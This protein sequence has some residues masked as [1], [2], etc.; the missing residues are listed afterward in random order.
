MWAFISAVAE[1]I[2]ALQLYS[3]LDNRVYG[4][5]C[6]R[7]FLVGFGHQKGCFLATLQC[8]TSR[9][10]GPFLYMFYDGNTC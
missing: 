1:T 6:L 10:I 7:A 9:S 8:Q 2:W 5:Y 4:I 3:G